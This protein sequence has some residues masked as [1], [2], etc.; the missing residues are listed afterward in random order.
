MYVE[1]VAYARRLQLLVGASSLYL[2]VLQEMNY[3]ARREALLLR[4]GL[5]PHPQR[6]E[7]RGAHA[8]DHRLL[9]N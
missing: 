1:L 5:L 2:G 6:S 3:N 8:D 9:V 4:R 7:R